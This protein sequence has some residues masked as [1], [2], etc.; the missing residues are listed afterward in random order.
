[1]ILDLEGCSVIREGETVFGTLWS[2]IQVF[3]HCKRFPKSLITGMETEIE[4]Q[5]VE[6]SV[7][8]GDV[9]VYMQI[10][11]FARYILYIYFERCLTLVLCIYSIYIQN[12]G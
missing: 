4:L 8:I 5:T 3:S 2:F 11:I 9:R 1:M 10:Y 6:F 12:Q 7:R